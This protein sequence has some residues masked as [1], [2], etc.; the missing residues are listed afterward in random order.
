ML[1]QLVTRLLGHI[2]MNDCVPHISRWCR[3]LLWIKLRVNDK[4]LMRMCAQMSRCR[5]IMIIKHHL[6]V[7]FHVFM[8]SIGLYHSSQVYSAAEIF[9]SKFNRR[10]VLKFR[11]QFRRLSSLTSCVILPMILHHTFQEFC[12]EVFHEFEHFE[13]RFVCNFSHFSLDNQWRTQIETE[14]NMKKVF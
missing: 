1:S 8:V 2:T 13:F 3:H 5:P 12:F 6:N 10:L 11:F 9:N 14:K 4:T 7:M